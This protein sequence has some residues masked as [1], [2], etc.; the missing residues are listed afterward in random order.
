VLLSVPLRAG[1]VG[2]DLAARLREK[3][4]LECVHRVGGG[5]RSGK[6]LFQLIA[7]HGVGQAIRQAFVHRLAD[8]AHVGNAFG[9]VFAQ[10]L[11]FI[12]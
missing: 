5:G 9:E 8:S 12:H 6:G 11:E 1:R 3:L 10:L 7:L 2:D 4:A